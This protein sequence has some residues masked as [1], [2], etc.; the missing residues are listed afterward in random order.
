MGLEELTSTSRKR[1]AHAMLKPATNTLL[2]LAKQDLS[3]KPR[4]PS[5]KQLIKP[6]F[7]KIPAGRI[8]HFQPSLPASAKSLADERDRKRGLNHT[9]ETLNDLNKQIQKL[10]IEDKRTKWQSGVDKCGHRTGI[11]HLWRLVK[12][13]TGKQPHNSPNKGVRFADKTYLD[14]KMIANKF[15]HQ[16]TPPPIHLTGDK[17]KRQ[18]KLQFHQLPLTGT[19]SFKPAGTKEAIR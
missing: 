14:P 4:R 8:Q 2:M 1:T 6:V 19:P 10:V 17:S 18:L 12:G 16:F 15:D 5:R 3:N 7:S 9:D 13:L 11:S